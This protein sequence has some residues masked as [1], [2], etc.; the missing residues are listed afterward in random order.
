MIANP[1][2]HQLLLGREVERVLGVVGR[3][4][5]QML[6][7]PTGRG[8]PG[9]FEVRFKGNTTRLFSKKHILN[10]RELSWYI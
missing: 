8:N 2:G 7:I 10:S 3:E 1:P 6:Q 5:I 4:T 9:C